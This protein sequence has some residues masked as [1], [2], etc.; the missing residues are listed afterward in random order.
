M[1]KSHVHYTA[2]IQPQEYFSQY[3]PIHA[4]YTKVIKLSLFY[5]NCGWQYKIDPWY[6]MDNYFEICHCRYKCRRLIILHV[7]SFTACIGMHGLGL[8][9]KCCWILPDTCD[10]K[11]NFVL[12]E[13]NIIFTYVI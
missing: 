7:T 9:H 5:R 8:S 11:S 4:I 12:P 13:Q 6:D 3:N 2:M 10:N 1:Y